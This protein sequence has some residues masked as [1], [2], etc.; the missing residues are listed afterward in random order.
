MGF[1]D[2]KG[3]YQ[4]VQCSGLPAGPSS[5]L[6][7]IVLLNWFR[8]KKKLGGKAVVSSLTYTNGYDFSLKVK[9]L[10]EDKVDRLRWLG[11]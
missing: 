11:N 10:E 1:E 9:H 8:K 3:A 6:G 7:I 4:A 5:L 2:G